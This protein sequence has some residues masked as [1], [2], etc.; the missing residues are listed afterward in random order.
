MYSSWGLA[1][2]EN[3]E[4]ETCAM[5]SSR[6][7]PSMLKPSES[8]WALSLRDPPDETLDTLFLHITG[9]AL[10][11]FESLLRFDKT[12]WFLEDFSR[13]RIDLAGLARPE[14]PL[15]SIH[16]LSDGSDAFWTLLRSSSWANTDAVVGCRE[17]LDPA[18]AIRSARLAADLARW[19]LAPEA[20]KQNYN[21]RQAKC[22][23][24]PFCLTLFFPQDF[25]SKF[26]EIAGKSHEICYK[27]LMW[28]IF[29]FENTD[30]FKIGNV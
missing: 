29:Y 12:E 1:Y 6:R 27:T 14:T 3:D 30:D 23:W 25:Y 15:S 24:T 4:L 11:I 10:E 8:C 19:L 2:R 21:K 7:S 16:S 17:T 26:I 22:L 18:F 9:D 28:E 13:T 5:A 20:M